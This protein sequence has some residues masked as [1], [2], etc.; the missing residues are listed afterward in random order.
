MI[1]ARKH[2]SSRQGHG[3]LPEARTCE[4][5]LYLPEYRTYDEVRLFQ[6]SNLTSFPPPPLPLYLS[7]SSFR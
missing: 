1:I 4:K 6:L 3:W 7:F 2:S 5:K